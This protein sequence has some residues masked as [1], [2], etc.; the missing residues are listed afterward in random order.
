MKPETYALLGLSAPVGAIA[1]TIVVCRAALHRSSAR[2]AKAVAGARRGERASGLGA[3]RRRGT[4]SSRRNGRR[5]PERKR[6]SDWSEEIISSLTSGLLVVSLKG[7]VRIINPAGRR[8]LRIGEG[9]VIGTDYRKVI[10]E[11]SASIT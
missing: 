4:S 1:A 5:R 11:T 9:H 8:L 7:E 3:G 10:G 2:S 6:P